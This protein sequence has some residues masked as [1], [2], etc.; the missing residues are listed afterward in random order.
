MSGLEPVAE[1]RN[2][3]VVE[4]L[5]P[6]L[7][8]RSRNVRIAAAWMLKETLD[9]KC[10][11]GVDL[12]SELAFNADQPTGQYRLAKFSLARR[13]PLDA[14]AHFRKAITWDPFAP[15]LRS[16]TAE[17][18]VDLGRHTEA[19]EEWQAACRLVPTSAEFELRLGLAQA[20]I[21]KFDGAVAAFRE[22]IKLD[23]QQPQAWYN[24]GLALSGTRTGG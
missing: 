23:P 6:L 8:D 4:H 13:Q 21:K 2:T 11:A 15:K 12:Q 1:P 10:R 22:S 19:V 3:N 14:L 7:E 20:Q 5:K 24:L 17:L 9:L 16:R 18:L